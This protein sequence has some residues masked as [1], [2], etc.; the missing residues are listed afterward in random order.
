M[1]DSEFLQQMLDGVPVEPETPL[2]QKL[3]KLSWEARWTTNY[4]NCVAHRPHIVRAILA[5]LT[6]RGIHDDVEVL[7]PF[8]AQIGIGI[9]LGR[10]VFI[11]QSVHLLDL[12]GIRIGDDVSISCDVNIMTSLPGVRPEQ[13]RVLFPA[14]V[15]IEDG[16]W[17]GP[18]A[19]V[20]PG[21]TIGAGAVISP[22]SLV[23]EDVEPKTVAAGR[24]ASYVRDL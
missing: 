5:E 15:T 21:V 13:R 14:G 17:I 1:T 2:E 6:G 12:G 20:L 9:S 4:L 23:A 8:Y 10:R 7:P 24:P 22:G 3:H 19:T 18:G 16:V 11:D